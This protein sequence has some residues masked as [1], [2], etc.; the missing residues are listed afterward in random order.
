MSTTATQRPRNSVISNIL[1]GSLGNLIEWYDFYSYAVFASFIGAA[2]FDK[3][4]PLAGTLDA[5]F[6]FAI[7]FLMR[8]IGSWFFGR[9]A[10]RK[11]RKYALTLS[12][13][14]MAAGSL[15]I[16][17]APGYAQIGI[18]ATFLLWLARIIEGFS[19][20]GEY[21]TTA[22]YMSEIATPKR[23]G[24]Y[25][26]YQ[27]V[28]LVGGQVVA[29]IVQIILQNVLSKTDLDQWGWRIPFVI[30]TAA[31]LA[32]LWLRR[33]MDES[34]P[35]EQ[36]AA[37]NS[38]TADK[39]A[40]P[41]SLRLLFGR[42]WKPFIIVFGLTIGGTTAFYT[43]TTLMQTYMKEVAHIP[44]S[45]VS[46]INFWALVIYML[47]HP[48]FGLLS[49]RIGRKTMLLIFGVA[50]VLLTWP[51][52]A[53]IGATRN[54][55]AA[56]GLQ[57]LALVIVCFY[58]SISA[59][60]KAELFP[61]SVRAL[62]VGLAYGLANAIFGGSAPYVGTLFI[63]WNN[64]NGFIIYLTILIAVSLAVFVWGMRNKQVTALD[65]DFG[66]AYAGTDQGEPDAKESV[67][68]SR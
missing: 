65:E 22:T 61:T 56:F 51:I 64:P 63:Q 66:H 16:A 49:D 67:G 29:L 62:G 4:D 59:I 11:G 53:A 8:P 54:P 19:V 23:R 47:L 57:L 27:Y 31:A 44:A 17:V 28:T 36:V 60:V 48:V 21:G 68:S 33:G 40:E 26:S 2:F 38:G 7:S 13:L 18:W 35:E 12:V 41:G 55:F 24:Y 43:Y 37:A 34:I 52:L 5:F 6:V 1:R 14:M 32:V 30:G 25:S 46:I 10:D 15:V 20:G 42:Y 50:G 39:G 9:V 3:K 45:T 58:T